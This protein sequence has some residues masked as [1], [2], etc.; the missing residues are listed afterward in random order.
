MKIVLFL[1]LVLGAL[2]QFGCASRKE[3]SM[4]DT[5]DERQVAKQREEFARTLPTPA[6]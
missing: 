3:H 2:L 1:A 4:R 6:P 5:S